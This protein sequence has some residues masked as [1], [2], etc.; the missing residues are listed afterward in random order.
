MFI[1]PDTTSFLFVF[2][3]N[4]GLMTIDFEM[5]SKVHLIDQ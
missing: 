4:C 2:V 3:N 1:K 5:C